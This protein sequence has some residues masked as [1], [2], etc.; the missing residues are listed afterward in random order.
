M[1]NRHFL[2]TL[3]VC[4]WILLWIFDISI[5]SF[6]YY[7]FLLL[8]GLIAIGIFFIREIIEPRAML[9]P[10]RTIT[11][12][13]SCIV[14][15]NLPSG[16]FLYEFGVTKTENEN[17]KSK[18]TILLVHGNANS[19]LEVLTLADRLK[20]KEKKDRILL[21]EY[22]GFGASAYSQH[23]SP[24]Q[25]V[26]DFKEAMLFVPEEECII[27]GF[28]I[29]GAVV[30][31]W[32]QYT[33]KMPLQIVLIN[34]FADLPHLAWKTLRERTR[35]PL[36]LCGCILQVMKHKWNARQ[37]LQRFIKKQERKDIVIIVSS[38]KDEL[39]PPEHSTEL[40]QWTL[41]YSEHIQLEEQHVPDW[42]NVHHQLWIT[43]LF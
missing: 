22:R 24:N 18:K 7:V 21:L 19:V 16:G 8:L 26:D 23:P 5:F 33:D 39:M 6:I 34:T 1:Q 37:G 20:K 10:S 14:L 13:K 31:Q 41:P 43:K 17:E 32:L 30:T 28:S 11:H 4:L 42:M 38:T 9:Y 35:L 12:P 3:C 29:G 36:W 15:N 27:I 2:L 40:L 25:L